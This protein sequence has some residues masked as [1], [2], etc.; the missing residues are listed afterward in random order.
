MTQKITLEMTG[1][2]KSIYFS[3]ETLEKVEAL[4]GTANLTAFVRQ[5]IDTEHARRYPSP[6]VPPTQKKTPRKAATAQVSN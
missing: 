3:A 4:N 2:S 5:L 1:V 6:T